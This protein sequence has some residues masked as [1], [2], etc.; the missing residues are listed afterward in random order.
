MRILISLGLALLVS[1]CSAQ[2]EQDGTIVVINGQTQLVQDES[3]S[4]ALCKEHYC[5]PNY[6]VYAHFGRRRVQPAPQPGPIPVPAPKL[7]DS[8]TSPRRENYAFS[9]LNV[10][11][12]WRRTQGSNQTVAIIDSGIEIQHPDLVNHHSIN[13]IEAN[14][15]TGVDDDQNGLVDDVVGFDFHRQMGAPHDESGHGT[16]VAGI[17]HQIAP[18]AKVLSL[19][20]ID[21]EGRGSTFNAIRAIDYAIQRRVQVINASWGGSAYSSLLDQAIQRAVQAG[22]T[23]VAAAGN[24]GRSLD[25]R[26]SYPANMPNVVS[27]A[28]SNASDTLSDFSNFGSNVTLVAP[29]EDIYST[30][31]GRSWDYMSGTSMAAPQVAGAIA[32]LK[33]V[34]PQA[35]SS[36]IA[37]QLCQS[38]DAFSNSGTSRCGR[39][40]VGTAVSRF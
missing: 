40:N 37:Q 36:Q 12:A 34:Q 38:S 15:R 11:P 21:A 17:V 18:Q 23:F 19:K 26:S 28:S 7:P 27:V 1:S 25:L 10:E 9:I 8:G 32:L 4:V 14:G 16:H 30:V 35:N 13:A 39:M 29:G 31:M 3:K 22:I 24:E 5:E 2:L 33:S 20:F 6:I